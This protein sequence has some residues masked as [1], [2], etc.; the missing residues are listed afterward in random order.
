M[1]RIIS[2][3]FLSADFSDLDKDIEMLNGSKAEWFHL[4]IMD[5]VFVPN[6][7]FGFPV[8]EA[9]RKKTDKV[10][11]A[12]LMIIEPDRY[13]ERFA[14]AGVNYLT[15]HAEAC[16]HLHRTVQNIRAL[17]MKCGVAL[18][19][20][21]PLS[22]IEEVVHLADMV[23]IMSVN[24][25]FAAQSF[26]PESVDKVRRLRRMIRERNTETLIQIDGGVSLANAATLFDA[27]CDVLVAGNA[28]FKSENPR[29]TIEKLLLA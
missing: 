2:P 5:G 12:H 9:I 4:D 13:I 19:P 21:T 14:Q 1:S 15:V 10:L 23:L 27:G 8:I 24:P 28:V 11:D 29:Q 22:A 18:N 16:V 25:G 26:I 20:H 6:I 3:S 17:G 7:S